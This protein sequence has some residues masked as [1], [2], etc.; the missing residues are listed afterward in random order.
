MDL[1][2]KRLAPPKRSDHATEENSTVDLNNFPTRLD[3]FKFLGHIVYCL[4]AGAAAPS[5]CLTERE[6]VFGISPLAVKAYLS[7]GNRHEP[8]SGDPEVAR[9]LAGGNAPTALIY[10]DPKGIFR[11]FYPWLGM[12]G[13][14]LSNALHDQDADVD[15]S[16]LPSLPA[17][18]RHLGPT[19]ATV[20]RTKGGIE[21]ASRGTIPLPAD[22][23]TYVGLAAAMQFQSG[24]FAIP[25]LFP[26]VPAYSGDPVRRTQ[27]LSF[28]S[29]AKQKPATPATAPRRD[30][31]V[32]AKGPRRA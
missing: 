28:T 18:D 22:A 32:A 29:E 14:A 26:L 15:L 20:R 31:T 30:V 8:I 7:R 3:Q 21:F 24:L 13:P 25:G 9:L 1:L 19:M 6:L 10:W 11:F 17:I 2:S 23:A 12:Y 4:N 16:L 5:W 27:T